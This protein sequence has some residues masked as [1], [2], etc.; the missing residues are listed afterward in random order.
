M[1]ETNKLM[2]EID[3][4]KMNKKLKKLITLGVDGGGFDIF[5][6]EYKTIVEDGSSGG[7][8]DE[9][10]DPVSS[11]KREYKTFEDFWNY[12]TATHKE[13][14]W[15]FFHPVFIH[16]DIKP[17][18][19]NAVDNYDYPDQDAK[20]QIEYWKYKLNSRDEWPE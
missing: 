10:E 7:M 19:Q 1:T 3:E 13:G 5:E 14:F 16:E 8:L 6:T 15:I 4:I 2:K 9:D 17:F 20:S 18:I 12:F 11:W